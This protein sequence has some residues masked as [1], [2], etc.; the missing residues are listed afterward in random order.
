MRTNNIKRI[1]ATA[2]SYLSRSGIQFNLQD[3]VNAQAIAVDRNEQQIH[4]LVHAMLAVAIEC[5]NKSDYIS[6]IMS[7]SEEC[8][9]HLMLLIESAMNSTGETN[10]PPAQTH[11]YH[12]SNNNA[13]TEEI[14]LL[15]VCL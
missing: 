8:Q 5:D 13:S 9:K 1:I 14:S 6:T 12:S 3:R 11:S 15:L 2:D 7:L 10:A 4:T